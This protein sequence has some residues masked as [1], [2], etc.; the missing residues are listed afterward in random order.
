MEAIKETSIFLILLGS[1]VSGWK[2]SLG[3][4]THEDEV[5]L[6][7]Y[8]SNITN[9]KKSLPQDLQYMGDDMLLRS[10][11]ARDFNNKQAIKLLKNLVHGRKKYS[12]F[13]P[14]KLPSPHFC[15]DLFDQGVLGYASTVRTNKGH[16]IVYA[17]MSKWEPSKCNI[18]GFAYTLGTICGSLTWK[19]ESNEVGYLLIVDVGGISHK[20]TQAIFKNPKLLFQS[21]SVQGTASP[22]HVVGFVFMDSNFLFNWV[23]DFT[24]HFMPRQLR[25]SVHFVNK[26]NYKVLKNLLSNEIV[27]RKSY[28]PS[29]DDKKLSKKMADDFQQTALESFNHIEKKN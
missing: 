22:A 19:W 11:F 5:Y 7:K 27:S 4:V 18:E 8:K 26:G 21:M 20:H 10:L 2:V 15:P 1:Y 16:H 14:E 29:E 3:K 6:E 24:K 28:V 23:W 13:F 17:D 9:L 12:L 25:K